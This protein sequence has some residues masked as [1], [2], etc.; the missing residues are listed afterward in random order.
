M[1]SADVVTARPSN[2]PSPRFRWA[3]NTNGLAHHR[4]GDALRL[5]ADLG[6]GGVSITPDVGPLD[7]IAPS[8]RAAAELADLARR[9]DLVLAVETGA[10]YVLDPRRKHQ[11][12]L[13]DPDP[14]AR[15]RR[16]DMLV[17]C[18]RL[19]RDLGARVVSFWSGSAPPDA[20]SEDCWARLCEGT[21]R[22]VDL[23][24]ELNIV[25]A[26]EPEP[27]MFLERPAGYLELRRRLGSHGDTLGLSLDIAHLACTG[28]VP[29]ADQVRALAAHLA[30]VSV[31]DVRGRAHEHLPL[32]EGELDLSG[33]VVALRECGYGG[34]VS[35]ELGRDSHRGPEMAGQAIQR[36]RAALSRP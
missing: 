4:P 19:A 15:L 20:S 25:L 17:S 10:R 3:Y 29:E 30:H 11:P 18:A 8:P 7:P 35:V 24:G 33:V 28:D 9:L 5:L 16:L 26:L 13:L 1:E 27:G 12:T 6:Y 31:A 2:P 34:L 23:T 36:L 22:L 32:G 14:G 21:R